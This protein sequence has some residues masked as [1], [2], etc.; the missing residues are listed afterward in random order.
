M[1]LKPRNYIILKRPLNQR[2][3]TPEVIAE[4]SMLFQAKKH[5]LKIIDNKRNKW[6]SK[7]GRAARYYDPNRSDIIRVWIKRKRS[8][9]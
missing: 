4:F 1:E 2:D 6:I 5:L 7:N 8:Y 9:K 3:E